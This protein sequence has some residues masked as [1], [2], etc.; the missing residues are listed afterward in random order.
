[1]ETVIVGAIAFVVGVVVS[2]LFLR[3]NPNKRKAL[4]R[5]VEKL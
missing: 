5:E 1:M 4:D 2:Y 3:V